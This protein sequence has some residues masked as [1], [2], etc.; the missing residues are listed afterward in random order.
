MG[1]K[2][3]Q[4]IYEWINSLQLYSLVPDIPKVELNTDEYYDTMK[5]LHEKMVWVDN[6][7]EVAVLVLDKN[8]KT[9]RQV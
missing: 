2:E 5:T 3:I 9:V 7:Y 8:E 1:E 6:P 4:K